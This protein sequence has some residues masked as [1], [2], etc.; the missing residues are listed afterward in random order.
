F[1]SCDFEDIATGAGTAVKIQ[2]TGPTT[3]RNN[4]NNQLVLC[5]FEG[6]TVD[7]DNANRRT[8][9]F[10]GSADT[11]KITGLDTPGF[12]AFVGVGDNDSRVRTLRIG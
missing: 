7:I 12:D 4:E 10:G 9:V 6:C 1:I 2:A 3:S 8:K 5:M 11:A